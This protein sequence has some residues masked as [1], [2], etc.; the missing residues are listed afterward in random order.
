MGGGPEPIDA[1]SG[2]EFGGGYRTTCWS[3]ELCHC[4]MDGSRGSSVVG[5]DTVLD[6]VRSRD[7]LLGL[8]GS[9]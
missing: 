9:A 1:R 7:E 2:I 3:E 6:S 5:V 8:L 4:G